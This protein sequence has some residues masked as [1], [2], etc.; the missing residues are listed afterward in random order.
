MGVGENGLDC[1]A[2][3]LCKLLSRGFYGSRMSRTIAYIAGLL[4]KYIRCRYFRLPR[5]P[6]TLE[7]D[8]NIAEISLEAGYFSYIA[9]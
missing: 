5:G 7:G 6:H 1:L 3:F 9:A 2:G 8:T 4:P